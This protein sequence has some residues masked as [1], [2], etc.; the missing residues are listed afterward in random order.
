MF[1]DATTRF[2][3]RVNNYVRFRPGY[4]AA[5]VEL[6]VREA[7]LTADSVIADIGSG[8]GL[9]SRPFLEAGFTVI[10]VEPNRE[11]REAGDA[12]LAPYPRFR[13]IDGKAEATTLPDN[14]VALAI[15]GQAFHWFDVGKTRHEWTRILQSGGIAALIWNERF[16]ESSFMREVEAVIDTYAAE[17]DKDGS[18][19]EA[20]RSRIPSFFAPSTFRLDQFPNAQIFG[21]EGLLGRVASCSYIPGEGD[22]QYEEMASDLTRVFERYQRAGQVTFE[23]QTK[24]FWGRL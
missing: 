3:K 12:L 18:I 2:N 10:G 14:S 16:V 23:Y 1:K 21:P 5:L 7:G 6:L 22:P 15:A 9:L 17:M 4:P 8:T 11:M 13:S 19:R 24:V 20:G